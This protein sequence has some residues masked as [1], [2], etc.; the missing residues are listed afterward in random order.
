MSVRMWRNG[1]SHLLLAGVRLEAICRA[2]W[3][4]INLKSARNAYQVS[5]PLGRWC[6][7]RRTTPGSRGRAC[8]SVLNS[9][10]RNA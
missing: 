8:G 4:T 1:S 5:P 7:F 10:Y 2:V 3:Q 6:Y 9:M